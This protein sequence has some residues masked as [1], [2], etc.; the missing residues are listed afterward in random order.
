MLLSHKKNS[1][2]LPDIK[3]KPILKANFSAVKQLHNTKKYQQSIKKNIKPLIYPNITI[4]DNLK[5]KSTCQKFYI[6]NKRNT[7]LIV[8]KE[9]NKYF[10][11]IKIY[12]GNP[13][14]V[15]NIKEFKNNKSDIKEKKVINE[16][17]K[18]NIYLYKNNFRYSCCVDKN[19]TFT[20]KLNN[21][22]KES[23]KQ[24]VIKL[25]NSQGN[26]DNYEFKY[27]RMIN[28]I[29]RNNYIYD[30]ILYQPWK[31]PDLFSV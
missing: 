5:K 19:D 30:E 11:K 3:T 7:S 20:L 21:K 23:F 4:M 15:D 31:Y 9:K 6:A 24:K 12:K 25:I 18:R 2:S 16:F 27:P 26:L 17:N 14:E 8:N 29:K 1:Q 10:D 13:I 22:P 28:I